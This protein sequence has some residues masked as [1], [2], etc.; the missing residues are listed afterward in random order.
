M[1]CL[2]DLIRSDPR[3]RAEPAGLVLEQIGPTVRMAEEEE[4]NSRTAPGSRR[5]GAHPGPAR[6]PLHKCD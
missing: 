6:L 1:V 2:P 3:E 4:G 5:W